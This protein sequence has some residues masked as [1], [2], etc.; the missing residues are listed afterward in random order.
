MDFRERY[1]YDPQTD[2]LG[3]GGFARVYKAYD[4]LLERHVAVKVFTTHDRDKYN[5][6]E[7]IKK[8]IR[9]EHP[10][11]LRYYDVAMVEGANMIGE[12]E[13]MQI[14]VME[15]ANYGDLKT[16]TNG[17]YSQALLNEL[18][19]Q[20]LEGIGYLHRKGIIH[21]DLKPQNIL[22]VEDNGII[23]AKISDFGISKNL[24]T[25]N[26]SSSTSVG[27]IEYMAPE[28][29]N[30]ARYGVNGKIGTSVDIWS[31]GI[32]VFEL[33]MKKSLFGSRGRD[34]TAEQ[35]MSN[36]LAPQLPSDIED[37]PDPYRMIVKQCLVT[38][39]SKRVTNP[40]QLIALLKDTGPTPTMEY[41][42]PLSAQTVPA[43]NVNN[44]ETL[45]MPK[46][47]DPISSVPE[48]EPEPYIDTDTP[49]PKKKIALP[50]TIFI[51]LVFAAGA[52][53][54]FH[55]YPKNIPADPATLYS[56]GMKDFGK[57]NTPFLEEL[58]QSAQLGYDSASF[59]LANYYDSKDMTDSAVLWLRPLADK[60]NAQAIGKIAAL[61]AKSKD[62]GKTDSAGLY[63]K[64][65][66]GLG[67]TEC[68][69]Q[70]GMLYY[71][72]T[73]QFPKD[74][75]TA[76]S[77][78]KKAAE[79]GNAPAQCMLGNMYYSGEG[80]AHSD[81]AEALEWYLKSSEQGNEVATY[82]LGLLYADGIGVQ[83]DINEAVKYLQRA[84]AGNNQ[85][86]K[87][88]AAI[89]LQELGSKIK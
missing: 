73:T 44:A 43:A 88:A 18:L 20:V 67:N 16:F 64:K 74:A 11:L 38:D 4:V 60:D 80:I 69:Y 40:T 48:A 59:A 51:L 5:V 41:K 62:L 6:L 83:K 36:I 25:G 23:N 84:A 7:E 86:V 45:V 34:T 47:K 31:F 13:T 75:K 57:Q 46:K 53:G 42:F 30:P 78:F 28:Q 29:F 27:T 8:A 19:I 2:L 1:T 89:K 33:I 58:V 63:Y 72:G 9:L 79:A 85:D 71:N 10:S 35:I 56:M 76:F 54:Y 82:A 61:W 55:F 50:L 37:L 52:Y 49:A 26:N 81:N 24:N 3:R 87:K 77:I 39:A 32:M 65:C 66:A 17:S 12:K 22:L 14:G 68:Q 21:R 70:L 15:L